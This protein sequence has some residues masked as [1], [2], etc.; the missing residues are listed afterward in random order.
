MG[1]GGGIKG[2]LWINYQSLWTKLEKDKVKGIYL[3]QYTSLSIKFVKIKVQR[4]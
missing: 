4:M 1:G 3:L 2:V